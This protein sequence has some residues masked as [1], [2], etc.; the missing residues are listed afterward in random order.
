MI[1]PQEALDFLASA[2]RN[3]LRLNQAGEYNIAYETLL[4][5]IKKTSADKAKEK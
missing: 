5:L 1:T 3:T 4:A 2:A